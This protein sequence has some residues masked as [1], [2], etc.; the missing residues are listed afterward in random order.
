MS[1]L[2]LNEEDDLLA[3]LEPA[4]SGP[5]P[6][7]GEPG[8][9]TN[10]KFGDTSAVEGFTRLVEFI[11][12]EHLKKKKTLDPMFSA[13]FSKVEK[14]RA[15]KIEHLDETMKKGLQLKKAA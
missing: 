13:R 6:L 8:A 1:K 2:P 7:V 15:Q 3:S 11:K 9:P 12:R 14:Y 4:E 5:A 10:E